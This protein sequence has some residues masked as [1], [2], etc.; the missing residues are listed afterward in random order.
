[1]G[2][3]MFLAQNEFDCQ[4][5]AKKFYDIIN[6]YKAI[7]KLEL[8][9]MVLTHK[10]RFMKV[11]ELFERDYAKQLISLEINGLVDLAYKAKEKVK[12]AFL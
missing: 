2:V 5:W 11:Y 4:T 9:D 3:A 7:D 1:M 10:N 8:G 6:G 12:D